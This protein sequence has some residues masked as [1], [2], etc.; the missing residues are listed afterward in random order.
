M[1]SIRRPITAGRAVFGVQQ[2]VVITG[3][4]CP[5]GSGTVAIGSLSAR[6][7][8]VEG[9]TRSWNWDLSSGS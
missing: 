5:Q 4:W 7:A 1:T 3:R 8:R 6:S 9:R 2:D